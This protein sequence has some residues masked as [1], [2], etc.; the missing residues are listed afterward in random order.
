MT[1]STTLIF[2]IGRTPL[3]SMVNG[4][5]QGVLS[6]ETQVDNEALIEIVMKRRHG[7]GLKLCAAELAL[8]NSSTF[9]QI[10]KLIQEKRKM[11]S[12]LS[13]QDKDGSLWEEINKVKKE[14][15]GLLDDEEIYWRQ[16]SKVY[17]LREGDG[18]MKFFHA[19]VSERWKQNIISGIWD[20]YGRWCEERS[21]IANG[22]IAY[23]KD[24]YSTSNPSLIEEV[25]ATIPTRVTNEM[26]MELTKNFT[27]EEVVTA[28]K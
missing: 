24:I 17:R 23:F 19:R 9:R 27:T 21:S 25:I 6:K 13:Q 2:R 28:L 8:W 12:S 16:R 10:P 22:A 14:I 26:N 3:S 20:K 1:T 11:L 4:L 15:N 5:R 7:C 18:N